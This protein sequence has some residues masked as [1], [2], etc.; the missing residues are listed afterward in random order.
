MFFNELARR[1]LES[2]RLENYDK[3]RWERLINRYERENPDS[4]SAIQWEG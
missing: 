3:Y 4:H 2:G 1:L